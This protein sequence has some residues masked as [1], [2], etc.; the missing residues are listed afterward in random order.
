ML[1]VPNIRELSWG[2]DGDDTSGWA[3]ELVER[4]AESTFGDALEKLSVDGE[5]EMPMLLRILDAAARRK[6]LVRLEHLTLD[7]PVC[8]L[9]NDGQYGERKLRQ[10]A[11]LLQYIGGSLR[12]LVLEVTEEHIWGDRV[13]HAPVFCIHA[14]CIDERQWYSLRKAWALAVQRSS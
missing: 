4:L 8:R 1:V 13:R 12:T 9:R 2:V 5:A 6:Q 7:L 3:S 10:I 11:C 14:Y